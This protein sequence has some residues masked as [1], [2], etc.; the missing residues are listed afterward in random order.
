MDITLGIK[1]VTTMPLR[2]IC[3]VPIIRLVCSK[4]LHVII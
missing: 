4:R 2:V 1:M 3:D